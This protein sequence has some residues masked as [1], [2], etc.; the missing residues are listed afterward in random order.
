MRALESDRPDRKTLRQLGPMQA[1]TSILSARRGG[2][3]SK[4]CRELVE[5]LFSVERKDLQN[6]EP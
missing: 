6:P 2:R 4:R 5:T 1:K 3:W